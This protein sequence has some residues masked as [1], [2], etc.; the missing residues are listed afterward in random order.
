M[1]KRYINVLLIF[2]CTISVFDVNIQLHN[3]FIKI[4]RK[5]IFSHY[6]DIFFFFIL[7]M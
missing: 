7:K 5:V 3:F 4:E 6:V 2:V 1:K